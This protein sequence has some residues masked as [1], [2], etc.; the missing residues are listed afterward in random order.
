MLSC[1]SGTKAIWSLHCAIPSGFFNFHQL[2]PLQNNRQRKSR[3]RVGD[4][5]LKALSRHFRREHLGCLDACAKS[6][7]IHLEG[8]ALVESA[9][10][11]V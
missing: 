9:N 3:C 7:Q 2:T 5:A 6:Y 11:I 10:V 4:T 8:G 1:A